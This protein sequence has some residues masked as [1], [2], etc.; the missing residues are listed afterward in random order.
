MLVTTITGRETLCL[1]EREVLPYGCLYVLVVGDVATMNS[2]VGRN[3]LKH[4]KR[5]N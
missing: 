4:E 1:V 2:S 5:E 3:V